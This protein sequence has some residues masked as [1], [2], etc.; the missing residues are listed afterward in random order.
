MR[1]HFIAGQRQVAADLHAKPTDLGCTCSS[2]CIT[3]FLSVFL[4]VW[5]NKGV[6]YRLTQAV[7]HTL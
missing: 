1:K 2:V 7:F 5:R 4:P 6:H 3:V